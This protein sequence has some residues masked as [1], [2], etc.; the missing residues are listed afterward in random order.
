MRLLVDGVPLDDPERRWFLDYSALLPGSAARDVAKLRLTRRDGNVTRR[1]SWGEGSL[2]V[3][4]NVPPPRSFGALPVAPVEERVRQLLS[5][6]SRA[7]T[8]V[9]ETDNGP[10]RSVQ[11]VEAAVSDPSRL[12]P[13]AW[14]IDATLT[15]D[16]FWRE[17]ALV[18]S[19]ARTVPGEVVFPEWAGTTGDVQDGVLRV[20]GPLTEFSAVAVDGTGVSFAHSVSAS[21]YVFMDVARFRGWRGGASSWSPN[22]TP[23]L[24]DYPPAGPLRLSPT[25]AGISLSVTAEGATSSTVIILRASKWWL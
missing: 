18:A 3:A 10:T 6:L 9:M 1:L 17:G 22:N 4:V 19:A 16:P 15:L 23:V 7:E 11:V 24:L 12:S 5:V 14:R 2:K 21:Q 8:V 20:Q 13:T 25:T